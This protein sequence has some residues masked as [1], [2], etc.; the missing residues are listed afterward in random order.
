MIVFNIEYLK[1]AGYVVAG[2]LAARA[3]FYKEIAAGK[4]LLKYYE[5]YLVGK[6]KGLE[7]ALVTEVKK[8]EGKV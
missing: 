1:I 5:S 7:S 8:F 3:W 4:T 6:A 2:V